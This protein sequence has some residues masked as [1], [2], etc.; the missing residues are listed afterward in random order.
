MKLR[1]LA[2][3]LAVIPAACAS[4]SGGSAAYRRDVGNATRADA[5]TLAARIVNQYQ[6]EVYS[7][8][9][10]PEIRIE[11]HWRARRPF[12]DELALGVTAAESRLVITAR[13]RGESQMGSI[14]NVR[15]AIDNRIRLAGG[16]EWN[17][18]TNTEMFRRYADE[19]TDE[20][21][22]Q[23]QIIGVRRY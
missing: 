22:K 8:D 11:T 5:L 18:S 15:L 23:I 14:F 12:A 13:T 1:H 6:Y 16:T 20:F 17:E 2:L 9:I 21:K 10:E 19:I 4:S 3:L 7:Q